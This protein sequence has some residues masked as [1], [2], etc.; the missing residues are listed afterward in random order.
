MHGKYF[1]SEL[2]YVLL[3]GFMSKAKLSTVG[4]G[5]AFSQFSRIWPFGW[6]PFFKFWRALLW[7]LLQGL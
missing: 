6:G 1:G 7:A 5:R 4:F 3:Y 2:E